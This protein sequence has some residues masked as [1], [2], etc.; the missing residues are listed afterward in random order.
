MK[1]YFLILAAFIFV[2][3]VSMHAQQ[4]EESS[5]RAAQLFAEYLE[6]NQRL[7]MVQQQALMDAELSQ[8][9]LAFVE[10][11]EEE[12]IKNDP[13]VKSKL[14][15]RNEIIK[16]FESAKDAGD[17][18]EVERL[19]KEFLEVSGDIQQHQTAA[20]Q[21]EELLE[22]GKQLETAVIEKMEEIDPEVPSLLTRVEEIGRELQQM[23][24]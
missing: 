5:E 16:D 15:S 13:S 7:Q 17:M 18:E 6:I 20:L 3:F 24:E 4:N 23:N 14:D 1:K 19:Q 22:E 8:K 12:M 2:G 21:N 10:K 11:V 9:S